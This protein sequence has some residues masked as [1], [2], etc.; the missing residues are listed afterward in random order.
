MTSYA[1]TVTGAAVHVPGHDARSLLYGYPPVQPACE[2]DDV[3]S[4]LGRKGLLYRDPATRLALCAA[5]GALR[6]A[7]GPVA[8]DGVDP[9]GAVVASSNLGNCAT[10]C[11]VSE[12]MRAE[13]GRSIS[14]MEAPNA[15]SNV[16][17][18]TIGLRFGFGGPNVM[19]CN[20]Q[21]SGADAIR[22]G[23]RLLAAGRAT[24]VLVVGVEPDD[25]VAQRLAEE[26][27][28]PDRVA[29]GAAALVLRSTPT[30]D[31]AADSGAIRLTMQSNGGSM[32]PTRSS[33]QL[34]A[35]D[36]EAGDQPDIIARVGGDLYGAL[37]VVHLALAAAWLRDE[38][39]TN[40]VR[41]RA[42]CSGGSGTI[43][44]RRDREPA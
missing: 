34:F 28:H 30:P 44:L 25:A 27:G 23:L 38:A 31:D 14:P 7:P 41:A 35:D 37:D 43:E 18:S 15:S 29:A 13:G 12:R 20:G 11:S 24:R 33:L 17:A 16:V 26:S 32:I 8:V 22:A 5:Q 40:A 1:A 2:P 39:R 4:V 6:L 42:L 9:G 21:T 19:V 3:R 10:V 36:A